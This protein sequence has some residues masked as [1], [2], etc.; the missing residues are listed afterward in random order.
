MNSNLLRFPIRKFLLAAAC[1]SA[2]STAAWSTEKVC[3]SVTIDDLPVATRSRDMA[4]WQRTT[5]ALLKTLTERKVPGIGFAIEGRLY[6]NGKLVDAR[7]DLLRQWLKAGMELG[8][9]SFSHPSLNGMG[10][11]TPGGMD[12]GEYLAD[13]LKGENVLR[14]LVEKSGQKLVYFR[15]PYLHTG[16]DA[17]TRA[18]VNQGL[19]KL[20][21]TIA[22]VSIDNDEWMFAFAY[23]HALQGG[24][25]ELADKVHTDY[26]VYMEKVIDY[27]MEQSIR[28][29]GRPMSHILLIHANQLNA[30]A[31]GALLDM[32]EKRK[33][34]LCTLAEAMKDPA[35]KSP[36]QF[37]GAGGISWIHRWAITRKMPKSTYEG[38]PSPPQYVKD[39]QRQSQGS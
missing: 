14:G 6:E 33:L 28:I 12:A 39:L 27:W 3:L 18:T 13:V 31:L 35:Y 23:E 16:R 30:R 15:H 9:H 29:V 22:P 38:E 17:E 8:N 7:V 2:F 5:D 34:P 4:V 36:D 10:A 19:S 24:N 32:V 11:P 26:L 1:A 21:Y 20:G 37:F 25:K